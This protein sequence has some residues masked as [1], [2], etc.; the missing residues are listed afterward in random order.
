MSA[1]LYIIYSRTTEVV[2]QVCNDTHLAEEV[3]CSQSGCN[4]RQTLE[5]RSPVS[6]VQVISMV[7][8]SKDNY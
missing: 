1:R 3:A 7:L 8:L 6:G 5:V 4:L 2:K